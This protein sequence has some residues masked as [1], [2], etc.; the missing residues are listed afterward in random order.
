LSQVEAL[1]SL[2]SLLENFLER[3][4]K[5]KDN[6][7]HVLGG[8]NRLDNIAR[9]VDLNTDFTEEIGSWFAQHNNLLQENRLKPAESNRISAIL[10]QIS[11]R[12]E[13][14]DENSPAAEKIRSEI[15]RWN[16][17]I[18]TPGKI[19]LK[20]GP[21]S[22]APAQPTAASIARFNVVLERIN[23]MYADLSGA[24]A[25]LLSVLDDSLKKAEKQNDKEALILSALIIYYLRLD[26]YKVS[27]YVR[28]LKE[29]E[30]GFKGSK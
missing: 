29:A 5:L 30:K 7:L 8:I 4:V 2:E 24:R 12:L 23:R 21:E 17:T 6:Q 27:P 16:E 26:R 15:S 20:R 3:V 19:V 9:G 25:H 13:A 11:N 14:S 1:K 28:R 18:R 10:T 22:A